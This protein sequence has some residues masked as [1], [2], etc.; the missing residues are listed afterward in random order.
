MGERSWARLTMGG[1]VSRA[2]LA[3]A[4]ERL[5][6]L[7]LE[8][9]LEDEHVVVEDAEA[10]WGGFSELEAWLQAR[11]IPFDLESGACPGAWPDMLVHFRPA[12]GRVEFVSDDS[13]AEPMIPRSALRAALTRCRTLKGVRAWLARTY[14]EV[15]G[16]EPITCTRAGRCVS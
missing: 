13:H 11:G 8:D 7:R 10:S 9:C 1:R 15:P 5:A 14:P 4:L 6:G 3:E 2:A 12:R 16:L